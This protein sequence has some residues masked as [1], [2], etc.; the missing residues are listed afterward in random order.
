M[1]LNT[2]LPKVNITN[3]VSSEYIPSQYVITL[4]EQTLLKAA[5]AQNM[6]LWKQPMLTDAAKAQVVPV[7]TQQIYARQMKM[8]PAQTQQIQTQQVYTQPIQTQQ[9]YMQPVQAASVSQAP[10][11]AWRI[12]QQPLPIRQSIIQQPIV[13]QRIFRKSE[14]A[15]QA[16]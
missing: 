12:D 6:Q 14:P 9:I 5:P 4:P 16:V 2:P 11:P 3:V 8:Q 10:P 1:H 7:H 15:Q 13:E